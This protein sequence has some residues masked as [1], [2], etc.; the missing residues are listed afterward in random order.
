MLGQ[1]VGDGRQH[2]SNSVEGADHADSDDSCH[3]LGHR[4]Q[5]LD[6]LAGDVDEVAADLDDGGEE[7]MESSQA[8]L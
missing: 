3:R 2:L 6:E 7:R 5:V 8:R 4:A 1:E